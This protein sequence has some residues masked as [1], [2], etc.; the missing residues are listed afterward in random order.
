MVWGRNSLVNF[1]VVKTQF[2]LFDRCYNSDAIVVKM[3]GVFFEEKL[4]FIY[5]ILL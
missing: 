1:S 3:N 4:F 2:V 5:F